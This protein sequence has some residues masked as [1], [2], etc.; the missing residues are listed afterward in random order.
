MLILVG[1]GV[2]F[3][4]CCGMG[5]GF[6]Y[7]RRNPTLQEQIDAVAAIELPAHAED[8]LRLMEMRLVSGAGAQKFRLHA[9]VNGVEVKT[10]EREHLVLVLQDVPRFQAAMAAAEV[11]GGLL[12]EETC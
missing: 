4:F 2:V 11:V 12:T 3:G 5:A 7:R 1:V 6:I 9:D 10:P 8:L